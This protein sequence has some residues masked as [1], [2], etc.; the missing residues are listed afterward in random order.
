MINKKLLS[1]SLFLLVMFLFS[2]NINKSILAQ[3]NVQVINKLEKID[4][5]NYLGIQRFIYS[6]DKPFGEMNA[7]APPQLKQFGQISG[8]W[9]VE[10]TA[11]FQGKWYC[12]WRAVWGFK[13]TIDG[14]GVQDYYVQ[15]KND[16]PPSTSKF[17]RNIEL[18]QL[19]VFNR[20]ENN[21]R[22]SWMSNGDGQLG[23]SDYGSFTAKMIDGEIIMTPPPLPNRPLSRIVF[24]A[25][26]KDS[27]MWR[28]EISEDNGKTW[29]KRSL[30]KA[31]RIM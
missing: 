7:K 1:L 10:N 20:K 28:Q 5:K 4:L 24:Y 3:E 18:T 11:W 23:G 21:W 15:A 16:L 31:K 19:R 2:G 17:G 26:K 14:F 8:V 6:G 22:I 29:K 9:E 30:I 27:F 13:Y 25:I 12:C